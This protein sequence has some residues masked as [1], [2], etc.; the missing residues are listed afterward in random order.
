MLVQLA[1]ITFGYSGDT[2]F[3]GLTWQINEGERIGLV[4]PNG[5]GKSTL[6]RLIAGTVA[7]ETGQVARV[8][9]VSIGYLQQSQEFHGEGTLHDAL[10]AP[11]AEVLAMRAE[12]EALAPRLDDPAALARYGQLEETIRHLDGYSV[13]A[14][15]DQLAHDVGFGDADLARPVATLSGGEQNRLELAKVLLTAPDLLLLDEPTNHLDLA[16]C[17][18]LEA[19]LA[20][21]PRA[22][23]LVSH[24][25]F[26]L[27]R[28]CT[29]IVD[30]DDG[31]L[32]TYRGGWSTYVEERAARR[33]RLLAEVTR[34]KAE[35][36]RQEDFIR[37]NIAGQ[38][39][40]QAKSRRKMLDKI[41]R[42]TMTRDM[43]QD[44]GRIGL[45]FDPGE[46]SGKDVLAAEKLA[47][48]YEGQAPIAK[49]IDLAVYRGDR[50]GIVGPNGAGKSTLL[51]T[52]LGKLPPLG[53]QLR[54]GTNVRLG[55]FDQKLA[56]LD[57]SRSLI[58]E[59]RHSR[60]DLGP[61]QVRQYLA[62]FRFTGDDVFRVVK[63]LSGGERNRLTLA[64]MML[65]PANLLALDEP[66]N[67]LDI[68]AREVLERALRHYEGT[69]L[70]ISHDRFFLD[71][72]CT[73]LIVI[74][75]RGG[76]SDWP[77]NYS[78]WRRRS[79]AKAQASKVQ[80]QAPASKPAAPAAKVQ[81][82]ASKSATPASKS[83]TPPPPAAAPAKAKADDFNQAKAAKAE[84]QKQERK[85]QQLEQEI[86]ELE[87]K[88]AELRAQ[89]AAAHGGDWQKLHGLVEEE[90]DL[91]ERLERR[92]SEWATLGAKLTGSG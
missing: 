7:P 60:G 55:Y 77:G 63:G 5:A 54:R 22:F 53:G 46:T 87:R 72:V 2:L 1:D 42:L 75:D 11:F 61:D 91:A 33:E 4:G 65:R 38:K 26:F 44:A 27:D 41:E 49:D 16:A 84:R 21:Y 89:L 79:A 34:Q 12:L 62:K 37:K 80:V 15:V 83:A 81:A 82:P 29:Q 36:E 76:V 90:S 88:L 9:G 74:D 71:E 20:N 50:I 8:R 14:R 17:E 67:H 23:V 51:K 45:R 66:T 39:T 57:E 10:T 30:V 59:I 70:V 86:A 24:D 6:L 43:W 68:P 13:E 32:E 85:L 56:D 25:R 73:R 19:F 28:V 92:M 64:K 78:D 58:D 31:A 40:N 35:I 52:L 18:R 3:E 47:I 48:G 69:L